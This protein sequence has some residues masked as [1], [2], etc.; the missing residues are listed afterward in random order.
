MLGCTQTPSPEGWVGFSLKSRWYFRRQWAYPDPAAWLRT[1]AEERGAATMRGG[2]TLELIVHSAWVPQ[3]SGREEGSHQLTHLQTDLLMRPTELSLKVWHLTFTNN[4]NFSS[5]Y[6]SSG[7]HYCDLLTVTNSINCIT[8]HYN[9]SDVQDNF[10]EKSIWWKSSDIDDD[11]CWFIGKSGWQSVLVNWTRSDPDLSR[12]CCWSWSWWH[13]LWWWWL[14]WWCWWWWCRWWWWWWWWWW[15]WWWWMMVMMMCM[16]LLT[17]GASFVWKWN[18]KVVMMIMMTTAASRS[19]LGSGPVCSSP[20]WHAK[21]LF[22][23]LAPIFY[24]KTYTD[25]IP[26]SALIP[27]MQNTL[28]GPF[29]MYPDFKHGM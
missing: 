7:N 10:E 6:F 14:W 19:G 20:V 22:G 1:A 2:V 5:T 13:W 29:N 15:R 25:L 21:H 8:I 3:S 28:L 23:P 27:G 11:L 26:L 9:G 4:E 24:L 16:E 18:S 12:S 17:R